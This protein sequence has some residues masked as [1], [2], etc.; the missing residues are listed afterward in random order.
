[1]VTQYDHL[2]EIRS[3][4]Q[5]LQEEEYQVLES[6]F[7]D[8]ISYDEPGRTLRIE[9]PIELDN[10]QEVSI[11]NEADDSDHP[12]QCLTLATL[13][14]LLLHI[15]LPVNYPLEVPPNILS[16][17]A[18]HSWLPRLGLR[19]ALIRLWSLGQPVLYDWIEL[20][21][22]GAFLNDIKVI[23]L[24]RTGAFLN[25]IKVTSSNHIRIPHPMPHLLAALLKNHDHSMKQENF[26]LTPYS[27]SICLAQYKGAKCAKLMCGHVF[28]RSCLLDFWGLC[29]TEGDVDRVGCPDPECVK[30]GHKAMEED[31]ARIV[32]ESDLVRW[33][34][35]REKQ[36][37]ERD[38]NVIHCPVECCQ[39]PVPK[40][41]TAEGDE[42]GWTRLR[43]CQKCS[44]SF[45]S[46]CKRTW[47]GP[48]TTCPISITE[49]FV[50][51]YMALLPGSPEREKFEKRYG[52][53][54]LSRL[55]AKYEEDQLNKKWLDASTMACPGCSVNVEKS[56]GCNHMT[57]A[58]CKQHFCY[59]CGTKLNPSN[60]YSH[61][62]ISGQRCFN[63]LFDFMQG[64]DDGWQPIEG[65][66]FL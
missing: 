44:F 24:I 27:C 20:I 59:R 56:L 36:A 42:S 15:A 43:T 50:L 46:F 1:M 64:E 54:M 29:I 60:P 25:D 49:T 58:K 10:A 16:I 19:S 5:S 53:V 41:P 2:D 22:T 32:S 12:P 17:H 13:P 9:V 55:V 26:L 8:F 40:P 6:I 4:C 45:C 7:P 23:E 35:L 66:E 18:T 21:R 30:E 61:F 14:P 52:K 31:V 39:T 65:F 3:E 63:K 47:H 11:V 28:C 62:S 34:W 37:L 48:I 33:R 57:C 51:E 38:P